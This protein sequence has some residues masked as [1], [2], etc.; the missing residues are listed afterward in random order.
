VQ[1]LLRDKLYVDKYCSKEQLQIRHSKWDLFRQLQAK[2]LH[3]FFNGEQVYHYPVGSRDPT[4]YTEEQAATSEEQMQQPQQQQPL[5]Q[6]QLLLP[7]L[8]I[9][10]S[11][12]SRAK[13]PCR[14][15]PLHHVTA[16]A[17]L[18]LTTTSTPTPPTPPTTAPTDATSGPPAVAE[19]ETS[20]AATVAARRL[21]RLSFS[22]QPKATRPASSSLTSSQQRH[23]WLGRSKSCPPTLQSSR[24]RSGCARTR[25]T[26]GCGSGQQSAL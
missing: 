26:A 21:H 25:T 8:K 24:T 22:Q 11:S 19:A 14:A 3:P 2:G 6:Q 20:A 4:L 15:Q 9:I 5:Q 12:H 16:P 1:W 23:D 7:Q 18:P 13:Y 17:Q 10:S